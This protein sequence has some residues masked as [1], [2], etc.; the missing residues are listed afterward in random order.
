MA[1]KFLAAVLAQ[2]KV[3]RLLLRPGV[4]GSPKPSFR[5]KTLHARPRLQ[6]RAVDRKKCSLDQRARFS[7]RE[8]HKNETSRPP[9]RTPGC[10]QRTVE[11]S[12]GGLYG[13]ALMENRKAPL[14][15]AVAT[16]ASGRAERLA[17]LALIE[18]RAERPE[19]TL[20]ADKG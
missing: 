16:R 15:G 5:A 18:P 8:R 17:A 3:K 13:I 9:I 4:G 14:V 7:R 10:S 19:A 12:A 20:G 11:G 6:Q 2:S 1:Q